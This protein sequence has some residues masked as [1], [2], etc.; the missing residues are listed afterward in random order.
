MINSSFPG[1]QDEAEAPEQ[2]D[3]KSESNSPTAAEDTV[4]VPETP[5]QPTTPTPPTGPT[6]PIRTHPS[7]P[8]TLDSALRFEQLQEHEAATR[9]LRRLW[10]SPTAPSAKR[11][12][13]T[14][15]KRNTPRSRRSVSLSFLP[16]PVSDV[17][18]SAQPARPLQRRRLNDHV[19]S[20]IE[21][22][23]HGRLYDHI[24][25]GNRQLWIATCAHLLR[26]YH[27]ASIEGDRAEMTA[28][29]VDLL[30]L[31]SR[32]LTKLTRGGKRSARRG[33]G[34]TPTTTIRQRLVQ[35]HSGI[36]VTGTMDDT[37][38]K[39]SSHP[40]TRH[41]LSPAHSHRAPHSPPPSPRLHVPPSPSSSDV[42]IDPFGGL[43]TAEDKSAA[44]RA[45]RLVHTGHMRR[46]AHVLNS[47]TGKADIH[48]PEVAIELDALHPP[49]PTGSLFPAL[50]DTA[51]EVHYDDDKEIRRILR[52]SNNGSSAGPSGWGGNMVSI[53]TDDGVCRAALTRLMQDIANNHIPDAVR[54]LLLSSELVALRKPNGGLRPIAVG[55]MFYRIAA[56]IAVRRVRTV[57]AP[58]LAPYQFGFGVENG[59]EQIVHSLQH[60]LT[61]S[62]RPQAAL[63]LDLHNA[64]NCVDRTRLLTA[65]YAIPQ[66]AP[67]WRIVTLAYA[68][69]SPLLTDRGNGPVFLS[70]NGVRQG[71]PLSSLLFCLY[72]K[73]ALADVAQ[74]HHV[75]PFA[76]MDDIHLVGEP[77]RLMD[78]L[79][80]LQ[81]ALAERELHI[82]TSKSHLAYFHDV[83]HPLDSAVLE[84]CADNRIPVEFQQLRVLGAVVACDEAHLTAALQ[85][86][87][88]SDY[89]TTPFFRRL[90]SPALAPQAAMLLLRQC[91]VP[92]MN[93]L[94]RCIPPSCLAPIAAAFDD[95]VLDAAYTKLEIDQDERSEGTDLILRNRLKL[96]GFG[97]I[98]VVE[99]SPAAYLASLA[100]LAVQSPS[101]P[102]LSP[103]SLLYS[104][105]QST[106]TTLDKTIDD[107]QADAGHPSTSTTRPHLPR[108]PSDLF[109]EYRAHPQR[110]IKLQHSLVQQ[111]AELRF[112][113][114]NQDALG[115]GD[116]R[117]VAH[118]K[119]YS[120]PHAHR[121]K[122]VIPSRRAHTLSASHYVVSA[123]LNLRLRP[124][125]IPLPP[126]CASCNLHNAVALDPWHHLCCNSHKRQEINMRH[127]AV[128]HALYQH[129]DHSG[130]AAC[131]EPHGLS[132][133]DGRRP[134]LQIALPGAHI[135]TDVVVSH[136]LA[137]S[138]FS[139]A[140]V[141]HLAIAAGAAEGKV[142]KYADVA[143][144]QAAQF[145]PF[146]V[147][148][149]GGIG[150]DASRLIDLLSLAA[151]DYLTLPSPHPFANSILSS[152]AIA[153]QRG[154]ALAVQAGH[155]RA[156]LRAHKGWLRTA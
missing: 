47:T 84:T 115:A 124:Y 100:S 46:A 1:E 129:A 38:E 18:L 70:H 91:G 15:R 55:E 30:L 150:P 58:L 49:L 50:P 78:G 86:A 45:N 93:Y 127:D 33:H 149:T 51:P 73:D 80:F 136:P 74:L 146:S 101:F 29:F 26:L 137:P 147:E 109:T 67:I 110:V 6:T 54:D 88:S 130:A 57:A 156:V 35:Q 131:K 135:L 142:I 114:A 23:K 56:A 98:S 22:A 5:L 48:D 96:G 63:Q 52:L 25:N 77:H 68:V 14:P 145:I 20:P 19:P 12:Q 85:D 140:A 125:A 153:I 3:Q 105:I 134:D 106:L 120:A 123:R 133:E 60:A 2:S 107:L 89:S 122:S 90:A 62:D 102:P 65:L 103:S 97:L 53:L 21:V 43:V 10:P 40:T 11:T 71:D 126:Q 119:A 81:Q 82:N 37:E 152:V 92:K 32:V 4:T 66:L 151:R 141:D 27:L 17:S 13:S 59:C 118:Y 112:I 76:C 28:T 99:S 61:D 7:L 64:F 108:S 155:S 39:Y 24:N 41:T 75:V 154:N 69:D 8:S 132:T 95:T 87:V 36:A 144:T 42:S 44:S 116:I 34:R 113:A 104:W 16:P 9:Q 148:S 79:Q 111:A 128:V 121:W 143:S 31:P 117:R 139:V 72:I 94:A 138:H 83:T